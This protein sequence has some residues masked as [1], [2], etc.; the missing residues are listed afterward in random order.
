M[1]LEVYADVNSTPLTIADATRAIGD[2]LNS[3]ETLA[4]TAQPEY[5][6]GEIFFPLDSVSGNPNPVRIRPSSNATAD[7]ILNFIVRDAANPSRPDRLFK[8]NPANDLVC[9][10]PTVLNL[11]QVS[12]VTAVVNPQSVANSLNLA[13]AG[14]AAANSAMARLNRF[15][16]L[17]ENNAGDRFTAKA[18]EAAP[19]GGEG[20]TLTAEQVRQ[21]MDANSKLATVATQTARVDALIENSGGD[22]FKR[23]TLE[24]VIEQA[25]KPVIK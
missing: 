17:I 7:P 5:R 8:V 14:T 2:L 11:A 22:R 4:F 1:L 19:S 24:A 10:Y 12:E 23:K 16:D 21:E 3:V 15:N 18:L 20:S 25:N 6:N 13:P 9:R